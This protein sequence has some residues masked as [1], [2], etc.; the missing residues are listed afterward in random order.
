MFDKIMGTA[1]IGQLIDNDVS[2]QDLKKAYQ[3]SLE[4]FKKERKKYLIYK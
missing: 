4:N 3:E 2:Y 1:L